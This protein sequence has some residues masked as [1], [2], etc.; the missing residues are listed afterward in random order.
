MKTA[1][2]KR[3]SQV[4]K[5]TTKRRKTKEPTN[6]LSENAQLE[7]PAEEE[8]KVEGKEE[9]KN[10]DQSQT[11]GTESS[12]ET[13]TDDKPEMSNDPPTHE[14]PT[15]V[16]EYKQ[17]QETSKPDK[18][19]QQPVPDS[20]FL[21]NPEE[22]NSNREKVALQV[23]DYIKYLLG[24]WQTT[25]QQDDEKG[26]E[27]LNDTKK[28]LVPLLVQLRKQKL[29]KRMLPSVSTICYYL[30]QKDIHNATQ[31]YLEL[32]IG[33]AAFPVGLVGV[34]VH[35]RSALDRIVGEEEEMANVLLDEKTRKWITS[36]K[37]LIT[38]CE[39]NDV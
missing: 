11:N 39:K 14:K 10:K 34:G 13:K 9:S 1:I 26:L 25:L 21:I 23:R 28:C 5:S 12:L 35:A 19:I 20:S 37:R 22:I 16:T 15:P 17:P 8:T 32:S 24:V 31:A 3:K 30:Q 7:E 18:Q 36:V 38:F 6:I 33:K 27:L 4:P 2:E 29:P